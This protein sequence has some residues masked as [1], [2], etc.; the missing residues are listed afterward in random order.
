MLPPFARGLAF[1]VFFLTGFAALSYQVIWQ[2]MLTLFTGAEVASVTM[3]VA[4]FMA[5][6]GFGSLAGGAVAD[7]LGRRRCLLFFAGAEG[8]IGL[9]GLLSKPL[10]YDVLYVGIGP[11]IES[12]ALLGLSLFVTLLVPTFLMGTSLPLLARALA[13]DLDAAPRVIGLLYGLNT[14]GSALGAL[15]SHVVLARLLG[16]EGTLRVAA[17]LNGLAAVGALAALPALSRFSDAAGRPASA[18]RHDEPAPAPVRT[19]LLIYALSGFVAL[20]FEVVWFRLLG[21]MLKAVSITFPYLLCLYL[22][23]LGLG[24]IVGTL[25]VGRIARPARAFLFL[26]TGIVVYAALSVAL[27]VAAVGEVAWLE[28]IWA[29]FGRPNNISLPRAVAA[30]AQWVLTLGGISEGERSLALTFLA[31]HVAVPAFLFLPPTLMMGFSF[32]VLQ[33]VLQNDAAVL[34]RRVGALQTANILG[35]TLGT[36]AVGYWGLDVADM[37]TVLRGIVACGVVFL[38]VAL[39]ENGPRAGRLA[40]AVAAILACVLLVP[41]NQKLWAK[42]HGAPVAEVLVA[43]DASGIAVLQ[44]GPNHTVVRLDGIEHS[45]LPYGRTHVEL[46]AIPALLHP[47]PETMAIVGLGSGATAFGAGGREETQQIFCVEIIRPLLPLLVQQQARRPDEGVAALLADPRF[48]HLVGDGRIFLLRS[49][50]RYD[51]IEADALH[52]RRAFAG[53]LYSHEYFDL[54]R[55]RLRPG[56]L[57]VTYEAS[58]RTLR[59]FMR[60]FPHVVRIGYVLVGS[61]QP[62]ALDASAVK[63]RAASPFTREYYRRAGLDVEAMANEA[64]AT[65]VV[66]R[67]P[68]IPDEDLNH[69]LHPRD[70]YGVADPPLPPGI[71]PAR[72]CPECT[73]G[74]PR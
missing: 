5:G 4:A 13:F 71:S 40:A 20:S 23:G 26:Q 46:G 32:P 22:T 51:V 57:A 47:R 35:A 17:A 29:Y 38:A 1:S 18:G 14:I 45:E 2:R 59:T 31:T 68:P 64:L 8:L 53:N 61:E 56:G 63:A 58:S 10:Y 42:L 73:G 52:P 33:K 60:V 74:N 50:L 21:V 41:P 44:Q 70:E 3:I 9:F 54:L 36:I 69:D 37:S 67:A 19:W 24:S 28:R 43:E 62:I 15:V 48:E 27:L 6:L 30:I 65:A 66:L 16:F 72:A 34:G 39:S 55:R 11:R 49:A 25:R 12:P 7:R